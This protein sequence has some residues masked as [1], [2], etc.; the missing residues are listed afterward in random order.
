VKEMEKEKVMKIFSILGIIISAI[1]IILGILLSIASGLLML[2]TSFADPS[3]VSAGLVILL[4][5]TV[6]IPVVIIIFLALSMTSLK[7]NRT[8][9]LVFH[10]I[11]L[12]IAVFTL[13]L[14]FTWVPPPP[15]IPIILME[16]RT[17]AK[18]N[19]I[20]NLAIIAIV[21]QSILCVIL[22]LRLIY[23]IK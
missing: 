14:L 8:A 3:M 15:P 2:Q 5:A 11:N 13:F 16:A 1:I 18:L 23:H 9:Q 19:I 6:V 20:T 10:I 22:I 7:E 17:V 4:I 12:C 21:I